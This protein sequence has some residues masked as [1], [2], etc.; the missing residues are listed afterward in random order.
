MLIPDIA[1]GEL[2]QSGTKSTESTTVELK[3]LGGFDFLIDGESQ[4]FGQSTKRLLSL[5]AMTPSPMTRVQVAG[6]LWP[7]AAATRA[8]ANLRSAVWRIQ[9][10]CPDVVAASF[11][12]LR[13]MPHV[14]VDVHEWAAVARRLINLAD[15][16]DENELGDALRRSVQTELLPELGDEEWLSPERERYRQLSLHALE[17]LSER[18]TAIGWYGAA[19][20]T[21]LRAVRLDPFRES[22]HRALVF[23]FL[24][25]GNVCDARRQYRKYQALLRSELGIQ[26]SVGFDNLVNSMAEGTPGERLAL[27]NHVAQRVSSMRMQ[28]ASAAAFSAASPRAS[29]TRSATRSSTAR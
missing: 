26:P 20:E 21:A 10:S 19:V 17:A 16:M 15:H 22:A 25:E 18:F 24:A 5:L 8:N 23:A 29:L 2:V 11:S 3:L 27:A 1:V 6:T 7:D 28:D 9:R 14:V 13:L 12:S 4:T